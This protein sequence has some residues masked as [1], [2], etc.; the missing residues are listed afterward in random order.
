MNVLTSSFARLRG[1][2]RA[3]R[4]FPTGFLFAGI[5]FGAALMFLLDPT[6]GGRRRAIVRDK[7]GRAARSMQ[8]GVRR[9]GRD[10]ANRAK[11]ALAEGRARRQ[12]SVPDHI[13]EERVR[14]E[15]GHVMAHPSGI[16]IE[17]RNGVVELK[18]QVLPGEHDRVLGVVRAIPGV[19]DIDD[20]LE[21]FA[22][23]ETK[24]TVHT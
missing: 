12:E 7:A 5:G 17:S 2:G 8:K 4:V 10:L 19:R 23:P 20:D 9:A 18:G 11:G 16:R 24:P 22:H 6:G 13:I 15:L 14:A 1:F 21:T 3:R